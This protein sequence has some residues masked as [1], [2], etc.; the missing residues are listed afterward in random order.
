MYVCVS[1]LILTH[2]YVHTLVYLYVS[3]SVFV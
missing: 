3:V 2:M 1:R